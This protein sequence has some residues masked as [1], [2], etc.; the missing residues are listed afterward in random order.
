MTR[1]KYYL[2]KR[3]GISITL[4]P[5]CFSDMR[6]RPG[7]Q[8]DIAFLTK[9]VRG[10]D[11]DDWGKL[12][13]VLKY[14]KGTRNM[15]LTLTVENMNTVSWWV[16]ASYGVQMDCKGHTGMMM[17]LGKEAAMSF[18]RG[19]KLNVKS[20]TEAELVVVDDAIPQMMW[21]KYFIEAQGYTVDHNIL[22]QD[23]KS[24]I[25]LATNGRKSM[26]RRTK[27]ICHRYFLVKDKISMGGLE[28]KY[29]PTG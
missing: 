28:I 8:T 23:N 11:E 3:Q 21:G 2:S 7:I 20:S 18:S 22:Y 15:N 10:P 4:L 5:S 17:S 1:V 6:A 27:H 19:Q 26:S 12:K 14:L 29:A 24:T 25:Q 16:D 9:R 13:R